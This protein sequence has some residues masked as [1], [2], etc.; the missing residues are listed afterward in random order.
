MPAS[1]PRLRV[2]S[3]NVNGIRAAVRKGM[4]AWLAWLGVHLFYLVG[5]RNRF[6][7]VASWLVAFIGTKRPGFAE[8]DDVAI[9]ADGMDP[10]DLRLKSGDGALRPAD[11]AGRWR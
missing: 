8:Q 4:I 9:A 1:S 3:V 2:A 10:C 7:A 5:F 6:G 11:L